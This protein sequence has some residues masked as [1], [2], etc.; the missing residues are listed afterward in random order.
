M[1]S[2]HLMAG[3]QSV[4]ASQI[5]SELILRGALET[6]PADR[7]DMLI[8]DCPPSLG[9]VSVSAL[10]AVREVLIPVH[11]QALPLAGVAQF[12][13]TLQQVRVRGLNP[14]LSLTGVVACCTDATR[15]S[16]DVEAALRESFG[17]RVFTSTVRRNTQVAESFGH[18]RPIGD[19][20]PRSTGAADFEALA[21]ELLARAPAAVAA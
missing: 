8:L 15:L 3:A 14:G 9:L 21:A 18:A 2:G 12:V 7:W 13:R 4:L 5:G 20:A 1:P 16:R 11:T 6:L 19:Y 17:P 10:A